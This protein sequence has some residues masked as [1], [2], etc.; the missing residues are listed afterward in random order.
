[1]Q[2]TYIILAFVCFI[3]LAYGQTVCVDK[4]LNGAHDCS[5]FANYCADKE[6]TVLLTNFCPVTCNLCPAYVGPASTT[7]RYIDISSITQ[8]PTA[9]PLT[10]CADKFGVDAC[11]MYNDLCQSK[12]YTG[13]LRT[14]CKF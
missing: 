2:S 14:N 13:F 6:Y 4:I 8:A 7:I 1:M 5:H 12:Y 3:Q 11:T 10:V 9:K